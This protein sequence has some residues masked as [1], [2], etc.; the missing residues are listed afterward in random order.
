MSNYG[1]SWDFPVEKDKKLLRT[2]NIRQ[3]SVVKGTVGLSWRR[4][5]VSDVFV[6]L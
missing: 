4:G 5:L 6:E 2:N 3:C 1:I